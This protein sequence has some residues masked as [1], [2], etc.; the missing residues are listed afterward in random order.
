MTSD[1]TDRSVERAVRATTN[2]GQELRTPTGR[3]RFTVTELNHDGVV[4]LLGAKQAR[5]LIPW[6]ALE[7][8]PDQLRGRGWVQVGGT[9]DPQAR[10][11]TLDA[12][13]KRF[14]NRATAG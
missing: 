9:F 11:G 4:L 7:E 5:T 12:H 10:T 6:T 2:P 14:V 8:L 1:R 3:G 13:L